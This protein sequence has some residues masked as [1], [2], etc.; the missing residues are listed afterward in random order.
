MK[1][2]STTSIALASTDT[3]A[4]GKA[5]DE[6]SALRS[7]LPGR[8]RIKLKSLLANVESMQQVAS[9]VYSEQTRQDDGGFAAAGT[10]STASCI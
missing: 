5:W 2:V 8:Q 6:V 4:V 9:P 10:A 1:R 7:V 3:G